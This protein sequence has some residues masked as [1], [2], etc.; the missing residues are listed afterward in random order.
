MIEPATIGIHVL[1]VE[2]RERLLWNYTSLRAPY[3]RFY[4]NFSGEASV[5]F[6]D[7]E[8]SE[9]ILQPHR[10]YLIPPDIDFS[11]RVDAPIDHLFV[12]FTVE[13]PASS[14]WSN[15]RLQAG[16][17]EVGSRD[18]NG[19][20]ARPRRHRLR[21]SLVQRWMATHARRR[22]PQGL[23]C[24]RWQAHSRSLRLPSLEIRRWARP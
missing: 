21:R 1:A 22:L 2:L 24:S 3:W 17:R 13:T 9:V 10:G 6:E 18:A 19:G 8:T 4:W 11:T 15:R 16:I 20:R 14:T 12:H 5:S 7:L 23:F